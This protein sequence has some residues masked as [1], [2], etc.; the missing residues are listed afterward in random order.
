M[1]F[2]SYSL[3]P[4]SAVAL[5]DRHGSLCASAS[6][7][8][9]HHKHRAHLDLCFGSVLASP[10]SIFL[11]GSE[12]KAGQ[13]KLHMI[14]PPDAVIAIYAQIHRGENISLFLPKLLRVLEKKIRSASCSAWS[15][16]HRGWGDK[17]ARA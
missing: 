13:G 12:H 5:P 17:W 10:V 6:L 16:L 8:M 14:T 9:P 4:S 1:T 15:F 11:K 2:W 3:V 7:G